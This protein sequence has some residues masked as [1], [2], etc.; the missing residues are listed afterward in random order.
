MAWS[1]AAAAHHHRGAVLIDVV[2]GYPY[3]TAQASVEDSALSTG[4]QAS[5]TNRKVID[6]LRSG[7]TQ[8]LTVEVLDMFRDLRVQLAELDRK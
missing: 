6:K 5:D 4:Y 3:G 7:A 8:A 1:W 2:Q